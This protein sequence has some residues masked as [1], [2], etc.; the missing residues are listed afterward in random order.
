VEPGK[1]A[2]SFQERFLNKIGRSALGPEGGVEFLPGDHQQV[3][4]ERLKQ[5]ADCI[6][7][8]GP[9]QSEPIGETLCH[10]AHPYTPKHGVP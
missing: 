8:G 3:T 5:L 9:G 7:L 2:V 4:A 1:I 10:C 6:S